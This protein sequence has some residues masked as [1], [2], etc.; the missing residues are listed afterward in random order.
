MDQSVDQM[1]MNFEHFQKQKWMLQRVKA[2]KVDEE[3]RVICLVSMF[4]SWVMVRKFS[5]KVHFHNFVLTLARNLNLLKQFIYMHLKVLI[6]L[7]QKMVKFIGVPATVRSHVFFLNL[8]ST[9]NPS[10][11]ESV[12]SYLLWY[13]AGCHHHLHFC[14]IWGCI[15]F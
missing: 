1:K 11:D 10:N 4:P 7:F 2:E 8:I 3:N 6:A 14:L 5:K 12:F 15:T 9:K 13:T